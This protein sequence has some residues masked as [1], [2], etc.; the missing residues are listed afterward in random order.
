MFSH[1][2]SQIKA[3]KIASYIKENN[4]QERIISR[5]TAVIPP[6]FVAG[7]PSDDV[8]TNINVPAT[9]EERNILS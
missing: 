1:K 3:I 7:L 5:K 4:T 6:C 9:L 8:L 2:N